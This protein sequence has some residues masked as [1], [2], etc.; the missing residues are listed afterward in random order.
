MLRD[1]KTD[2]VKLTQSE[3]SQLQQRADHF[4]TD[5]GKI[6]TLTDWYEA[7]AAGSAVL[8]DLFER[9]EKGSSPLSRG[10]VTVEQL[11]AIDRENKP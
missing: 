6:E 3:Y 11:L 8:N 1:T 4:D 9:I 7:R 2:K 5:I 10:E